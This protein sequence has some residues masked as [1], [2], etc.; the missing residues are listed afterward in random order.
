MS[1]LPA[2]FFIVSI[3]ILSSCALPDVQSTVPP[4]SHQQW[5]ALLKKHVNDE[6][7][8]NYEGFIA[9]STDLNIYL[10]DLSEH[11]PN[12]GWTSN[13]RKAYWINAYN[14]FTVQL[15][16]RN[17]PLESIK[18]I[19]GNLYKINTPWDIRFIIIEGAD[20]DLNNIEHD[21]LR[22]RWDDP[23]IHFAVNCASISCPKLQRFAFSAK[24]LDAELDQCAKAFIN[25]PKFNSIT[26]ESAELSR[27]FKWFSGDFTQE[28]DIIGYINRYS[29]T[30]LNEDAEITYKEYDWGLNRMVD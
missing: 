24:A 17:Y 30:P 27:I 9:D 25:D 2:F 16:I 28:T 21:I 6:G 8:V 1:R 18:D 29:N 5:D 13:E 14:A 15:I 3:L 19:A 10:K 23:R 12:G 7:L 22:K 20:Y 26:P 4:V 11:H